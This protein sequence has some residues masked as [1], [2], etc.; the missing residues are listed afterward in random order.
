MRLMLKFS[1]EKYVVYQDFIAFLK[2]KYFK[3]I[4]IVSGLIAVIILLSLLKGLIIDRN[5][6]NQELEALEKDLRSAQLTLQ[7]LQAKPSVE[8]IRPEQVP[9][10]V[11]Q[12]ED[13]YGLLVQSKKMENRITD[14]NGV[15][16]TVYTIEG[17]YKYD[18]YFKFLEFLKTLQENWYNLKE[19]EKVGEFVKVRYEIYTYKQV[20]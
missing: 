10:V 3:V 19:V 15:K 2:S 1:E 18:D 17:I 7:D 12:L 5:K 16:F 20:K 14:L 11:K 13:R 9:I 8:F 4:G 6:L